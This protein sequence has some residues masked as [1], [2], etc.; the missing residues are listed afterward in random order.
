[1]KMSW[2]YRMMLSYMPIFFVA[3]SSLIFVFFTMLNNS[4]ENKY[5][6]TNRAIL[7]QM[8]QNTDANL[9][10]I[11]R[12][13]VMEMQSDKTL[14]SFFTDAPKKTLYD[15]FVIQQKLVELKSSLPFASTIYLYDLSTQEVLSESD[16]FTPDSFGDKP[17]IDALVPEQAAAGW[18]QPR[19]YSQSLLDPNKQAVVSLVKFYPYAS[20]KQG[21][22]V[23]NVYFSSIANFLNQLNQHEQSS[24]SILDDHMKP[25][26]TSQSPQTKADTP[27]I[28]V[29]SEYTGW[30]YAAEGVYAEEFSA[31]SQLSN[32]WVILV[33]IIIVLT[34]V[35][36]TV[37]THIN[38][39]PIQTIVGKIKDYTARK[40]EELGLKSPHNEFAFIETAID[41]LL[42]KSMDYENLHKQDK[43]LRQRTLFQESLS[44]N[45]IF[46]DAKWAEQM[47]SLGLPHHYNQLAVV[48]HEIDH[49][50]QFTMQYKPGDQYLLKFLIETA[51]RESAQQRGLVVWQTWMEPHRLSTVFHLH[52]L[53]VAS[54]NAL[55]Q[56]CEDFRKWINSNLTLTVSAGIGKETDSMET[57]AA[58]FRQ[59]D[60]LVT[61]K[62]VFGT[63]AVIDLRVIQT[64]AA[65]GTYP[66]FAPLMEWA[67]SYKLNNG[68]QWKDK[69]HA[70]FQGLQQ[71]LLSQSDMITFMNHLVRLLGTEIKTLSTEI[72]MLWNGNYRPEFENMIHR[73]ETIAELQEELFALLTQLSQEIGRISLS[74]NNHAIALEI[75]EF[76]DLHYADPDLSLIQ[77]SDR[78]D[79]NPRIVSNLFKEE[80]GEKFM[81]Y[82]LK[83][84]FGHAKDLLLQTDEPIQSIAEKVGYLHVIS[85]HRAFK[86]TYHLPPGEY[87]NMY[88]VNRNN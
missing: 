33:F 53:E 65:A 14:Q 40:S 44:G 66:Y 26:Q 32:L 70:I 46:T 68:E 25:F 13:V 24:V 10:L 18:S 74:R 88:R 52:E 22:V 8:A 84:R 63:N 11:E 15:Y 20:E 42:K 2:Y 38:Y 85:F 79:L 67:H 4:S 31:V 16:V 76:I 19:A 86:K 69:L 55:L 3:I 7:E 9:K 78:Y 5:I 71:T 49:Y 43:L 57:I 83:V 73:A 6:E 61:Y 80:M 72:Q 28:F 21:A 51:F 45:R 29:H 23:I 50:D 56:I 41:H 30:N 62:A 36:F 1:M 58:A 48:V 35:W 47:D 59:A 75:K 87:R 17:F 60:K 54:Q 64:K 12:N 37:I 34:L 39:K 82:L 81:D 77:V 27:Q